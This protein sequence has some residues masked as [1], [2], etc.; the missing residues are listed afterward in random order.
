[1]KETILK[2]LFRHAGSYLSGQEISDELGVSRTAVWKHIKALQAAGYQ[3]E[4]GHRK[5][6]RLLPQE[7]S[8]LPG[9]IKSVLKTRWLAHQLVHL[10]SVDSTNIWAKKH[11]HEL[12]HGA[13]VLA[14]EQTGGR[15]RLGRS[16]ESSKGEG[17]WM[18]L[19]LEPGLPMHDAGKMTQLAAAAMHQ[20]IVGVTGL[21]VKIKWPNDLLVGDHKICGILTEASGE[22][23]RIERLLV[24]IGVNVNQQAFSG[25]I[26]AVATSLRIMMEQPVSRVALLMLF[27][28]IF[29]KC[30]DDYV[31]HQSY[32]AV[33]RVVREHSMLLNQPIDVIRGDQ[34]VAARAVSIHEDGRLEVVYE[35]GQSEL[36]AGGEVSVRRKL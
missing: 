7:E 8:L 10:E 2:L 35:D 9:E 36:L 16:W 27:L 29:E 17:I 25:E 12:Q 3:I 15:G 19:V 21:P 24:G 20:A 34:R 30:Y 33:L 4:T 23:T 22:L 18:T 5:G 6:Y 31:L 11:H 1:M 13:L 14:E 26:A 28:E 32:G